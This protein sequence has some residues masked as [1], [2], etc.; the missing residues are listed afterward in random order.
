MEQFL[1]RA[2]IV[3]Y[4]I[5]A[6]KFT[7]KWVDGYIYPESVGTYGPRFVFATLEPGKWDVI[8]SDEE[9]YESKKYGSYLKDTVS[10]WTGLH[11]K[12]GKKIFEG[13]IIKWETLGSNYI[14]LVVEFAKGGYVA[15]PCDPDMKHRKIRLGG[16]QSY[17]EVIGNRWDNPEMLGG[18]S[19]EKLSIQR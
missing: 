5:G 17:C 2:K 14:Y 19:N 12:N 15:K 7:C 4:D 9:I 13:D 1:L 18:E 16:E 8:S 10:R 6:N 11:D 3:D